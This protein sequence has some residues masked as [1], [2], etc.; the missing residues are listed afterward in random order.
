M[1][2]LHRRPPTIAVFRIRGVWT[3]R[4]ILHYWR[5]KTDEKK[6]RE[7]S[8]SIVMLIV[9]TWR[10]FNLLL[11]FPFFP[12]YGLFLVK[13]TGEPSAVYSSIVDRHLHFFLL[14]CFFFRVGVELCFGIYFWAVS[15]CVCAFAFK[16]SQ[17]ESE[18]DFM[19]QNRE[20]KKAPPPFF[21]FLTKKGTRSQCRYNHTKSIQ[22]IHWHSAAGELYVACV[23]RTR[24]R[25]K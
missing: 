10:D 20:W 21:L 2:R 15:A 5:T 17:V 16:F 3:R 7:W 9:D 13:H 24:L 25:N 23:A 14:F 19:P 4:N 11:L 1:K 8:V 6:V 12:L 22:N 18:S